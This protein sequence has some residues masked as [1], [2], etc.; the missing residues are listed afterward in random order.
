MMLI[1]LIALIVVGALVLG[2]SPGLVLLA[3]GSAIWAIDAY[4]RA[5]LRRTS[6]R[7]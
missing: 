1:A 2:V 6:D 4:E 5:M 7:R 3:G